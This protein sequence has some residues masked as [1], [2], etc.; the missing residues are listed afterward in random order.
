MYIEFSRDSTRDTPFS[1]SLQD[2]QDR[3][4][5]YVASFEKSLL[6]RRRKERSKIALRRPERTRKKVRSRD[7]NDFAGENA[8]PRRRWKRKRE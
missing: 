3:L 7:R 6:A 1:F 8:R 5:P 2:F 4:G